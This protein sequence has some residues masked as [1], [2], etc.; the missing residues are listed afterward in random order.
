DKGKILPQ[1]VDD[2]DRQ[3]DAGPLRLGEERGIGVAADRR[4]PLP[5]LTLASAAQDEQRR[6]AELVQVVDRA[7]DAIHSPTHRAACGAEASVGAEVRDPEARA[8]EQA[9]RARRPVGI[10]LRAR[11]A[12][13][14][15]ADALEVTDRLLERPA[16]GA[17]V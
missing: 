9:D 11:Q 3:T 13:R 16:A 15:E 2:L 17:V 5:A 4:R 14:A 10:E 1:G 6:A 12:D 7:P 8:L